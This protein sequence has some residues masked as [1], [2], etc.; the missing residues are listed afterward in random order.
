MGKVILCAGR[1]AERPFA[2]EGSE[3]KIYSIEELDYYVVENVFGIDLSFFNEDLFSFVETELLLPE[4][5]KTMRELVA[6]GNDLKDLITAI[7]CASDLYDR[8]EILGVIRT[9]GQISS[10]DPWEK[11]AHIGYQ[12]LKEGNYFSALGYF[13]GILKEERIS[14]KDYGMILQAMGL[15]LIRTSSYQGAADCFYKAYKYGRT[16]ED[17]M[18]F[19]LSIKLGNLSE[20]F[21]K[22][23]ETLSPDEDVLKEVDDIWKSVCEKAM[24]SQAYLEVLTTLQEAKKT[25]N[26]DGIEQKL[27][28]WKKEYREG[29]KHGLI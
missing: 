14:E 21:E 3:R 7:L 6:K 28:E 25:G 12:N 11:R 22:K 17:L 2:I 1:L 18:Y 10:M 16:R 27:Q 13:R 20:E 4:V 8:E 24:G 19:L 29:M 15:C 23:V 5:A 26:P 9:L